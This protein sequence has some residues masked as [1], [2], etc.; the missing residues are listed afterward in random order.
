[1][2][3]P[4]EHNSHPRC[5]ARFTEIAI[6]LEYLCS[7]GAVEAAI[8]MK[9]C[10]NPNAFSSTFGKRDAFPILVIK[11]N[12]NDGTPFLSNVVNNIGIDQL[13]IQTKK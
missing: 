7:S 11:G 5:R 8:D 1:M 10:S 3:Q 2:S 12:L 9:F 4:K 13:L 6:E